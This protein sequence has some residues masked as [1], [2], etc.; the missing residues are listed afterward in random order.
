[1]MS[2]CSVKRRQ[3][4]CAI[5]TP[6]QWTTVFVV[7]FPVHS[8]FG[9]G[10]PIWLVVPFT[11]TCVCACVRAC[12]CVYND[13]VGREGLRIRTPSAA[14]VVFCATY[15]SDVKPN[16]T[17]KKIKTVKIIFLSTDCNSH[18]YTRTHMAQHTL[19]RLYRFLCKSFAHSEPI[20]AYNLNV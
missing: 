5:I 12:V 16:E 3:T 14:T 9:V 17:P 7:V 13:A 11:Y 1:M 20:K 4:S 8:C 2:S 18:C 15:V 6:Q 19:T 10:R